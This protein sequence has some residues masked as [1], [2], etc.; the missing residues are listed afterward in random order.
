MA[1]V[2]ITTPA[3]RSIFWDWLTRQKT[4]ISAQEKSVTWRQRFENIQGPCLVA[5][6]PHTQNQSTQEVTNV[7]EVLEWT[8]PLPLTNNIR[9]F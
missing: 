6:L 5:Q 2:E 9:N 7:S 3:S 1:G 8:M 4:L